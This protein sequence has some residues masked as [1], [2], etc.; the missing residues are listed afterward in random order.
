MYLNIL[1]SA[2]CRQTVLDIH[3]HHPIYYMTDV[4]ILFSRDST[5]YGLSAYTDLRAVL[6]NFSDFHGVKLSYGILEGKRMQKMNESLIGRCSYGLLSERNVK[7]QFYCFYHV[8]TN[9]DS[10]K[11]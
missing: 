8:Q 3:P 11:S 10:I 9:F 5:S 1:W 6:H 7:W 2:D 4:R